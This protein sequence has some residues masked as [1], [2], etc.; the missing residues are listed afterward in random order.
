M[1]ANLPLTP[2]QERGLAAFESA[3]ERGVETPPQLMATT[4]AVQGALSGSALE[5]AAAALLDRHSALRVKIGRD[6]VQSASER[7]R[8]LATFQRTGWL[9]PGLFVQE[10]IENVRPR[11]ERVD[12]CS[13]EPVRHPQLIQ[14]V[15]KEQFRRAFD[16]AKPPHM[17]V[18]WITLSAT[19]HVVVVVVDHVVA[20]RISV[21]IVARDL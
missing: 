13:Q 17:R 6:P 18:V 5:A 15:V 4:F 8:R 7:A 14:E 11:L 21:Q 10:I 19:T 1:V 9:E 16:I 2:A 3:S 12:L 20:D